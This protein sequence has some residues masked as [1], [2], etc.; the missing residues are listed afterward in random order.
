MSPLL[1][2]SPKK[3]L[4]RDMLSLDQNQDANATCRDERKEGAQA[5][6]GVWAGAWH[7]VGL[8][9]RTFNNSFFSHPC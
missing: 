6:V 3:A 2:P 8:F 7:R 4:F 1:Y 9:M 5:R